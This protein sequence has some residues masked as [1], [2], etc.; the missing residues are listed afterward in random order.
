MPSAIAA[1]TYSR[2]QIGVLASRI[3]AEIRRTGAWTPV[4]YF[5]VLRYVSERGALTQGAQR[6]AWLAAT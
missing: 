6:V 2:E 5:S 4:T 3:S 1:W